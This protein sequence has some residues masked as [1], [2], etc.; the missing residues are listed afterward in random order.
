MLI[1]ENKYFGNGMFR[2]YGEN[3][4]ND[5]SCVASSFDPSPVLTNQ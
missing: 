5:F 2:H 1:Y 3:V 4:I